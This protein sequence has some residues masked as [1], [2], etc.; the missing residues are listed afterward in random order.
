MIYDG[1][2]KSWTDRQMSFYIFMYLVVSHCIVRPDSK[3]TV[4]RWPEKVKKNEISP[5]KTKKLLLADQNFN[6][7]NF[8]SSIVSSSKNT[9]TDSV[10]SDNSVDYQYVCGKK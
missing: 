6:H 7:L 2:P 9:N 10:K 3:F 5:L 1:V 8:H 4:T